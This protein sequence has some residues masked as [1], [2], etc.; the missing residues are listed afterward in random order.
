ML[1][2]IRLDRAAL[3]SWHL[4]LAERLNR[5]P[6]VYVTVSWGKAV[7]PLPS[8]VN[9]LFALERL[10]HGL[11]E[12]GPSSPAEE[13]V[14][15][16]Y[17][18]KFLGKPDLILDLCGT[19][20]PD[21]TPTWFVTFDEG[22]GELPAVAA[23][24]TRRLPII[25]V[26]D[27]RTGQRVVSG[28]PGT[29][30]P[31]IVIAALEDCF[32]RT[33]TLII[34]AIRAAGT[35]M[36]REPLVST[37][38]RCAAVAKLAAKSVVANVVHRL[39][40]LC[41]HSPHW[42]VGWR[43]VDGPDVIDL[44]AHPKE[45][46]QTLPDDGLHFY[47]DPFPVVADNRTYLF[48]EDYD[49]R[50]GRGVISVVAFDED[51]PVDRPR[52]VLTTDAHLSYPFVF[53]HAGN[54]WMI[55]ECLAA[56]RIDLY[57]AARFPDIWEFEATLVADI[58]ASDT[59]LLEKDGR[60]W[61]MATVRD[62]GGSFSDALYLWWA[63][64]PLGPW[65][66]HR[67]NPVLVDIA[68]ARP[69]GRVVQRGGRFIRPIQDCRQGYGVALSLAE[70]TRL[71]YDGF[72][73]TVLAT[74]RTGDLWPGRRLHTLNR[75]GRLECIDGSALAFKAKHLLPRMTLESAKHGFGSNP[76]GASDRRIGDS[77]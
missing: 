50:Y 40:R 55:P 76:D 68:A 1:I 19:A 77:L 21:L 73:Q 23:L 56:R 57:R 6:Q 70:I 36:P 2:E 42:R 16:R 61:M 71:D 59:T 38:I 34:G 64:S 72:A 28:R 35:N 32:V 15:S 65:K 54:M 69:A 44:L 41:Y 24:L 46:W 7:E 49:H 51:G 8:C 60:W 37:G 67:K 22:F 10:I 25:A 17:S 43:F 66:A 12:D 20:E 39:Y 11:P 48:V 18:D 3:R 29:E 30:T 63:P 74:L 27:A 75:A 62:D 9:L 52:P 47:A 13:V 4:R 45:G 14:F 26:T 31:G 58:E 53:E 33:T 5:I